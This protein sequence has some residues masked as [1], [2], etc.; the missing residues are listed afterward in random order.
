[1][2]GTLELGGTPLAS[3][4]RVHLEVVFVGYPVAIASIGFSDLVVE[5]LG[6]LGLVL[7]LCSVVL[8]L[9]ELFFEGVPRVLD[10]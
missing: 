10:G 7:V 5:T 8:R 3:L 1:M 9:D 4:V 6:Y 2:T